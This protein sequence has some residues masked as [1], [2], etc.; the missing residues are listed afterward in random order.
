MAHILAR[1]PKFWQL[2]S[3]IIV[4]IWHWVVYPLELR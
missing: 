3:R 2:P 1:V 4:A